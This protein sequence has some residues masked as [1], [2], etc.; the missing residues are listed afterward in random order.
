MMTARR[1]SNGSRQEFPSG[2]HNGMHNPPCARARGHNSVV[3]AHLVAAHALDAAASIDLCLPFADDD[4]AHRAGILAR[5]A[6]D[7]ILSDHPRPDS[8]QTHKELR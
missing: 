6:S 8:E 7:A 5:G 4:R 2:A 3:A 1:E